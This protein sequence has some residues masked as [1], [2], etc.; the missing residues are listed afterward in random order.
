[1]QGW[2]QLPDGTWL[3]ETTGT[4]SAPLQDSRGGGTYKRGPQPAAGPQGQ[5]IVT[6]PTNPQA[7]MI[8]GMGQISTGKK[9]L[10]IGAVLGVAVLTVWLQKKGAGKS[11]AKG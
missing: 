9:V 5:P 10:L 4:V 3:N 1:M 6:Q 11:K 7:T 2:R 8:N